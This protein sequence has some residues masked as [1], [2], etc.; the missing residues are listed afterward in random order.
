MNIISNL[1]AAF[2]A[3]VIGAGAV[4]AFAWWLFRQFSER[5]LNAKFEERL[6]A[7][8]HE[9]QKELE[10]LKFAINAQMD[11]ATK[12]HQREFDALPEAWAKLM[13]AYGIIISLVSRGQSMPDLSRM[14][15]AQL[16]DFLEH[17]KLASWERET[18]RESPDKTNAYRNAIEPFKIARGRKAS[19]KFY[20]YFR[21]NGIF[22]REPIKQKFVELDNLLLAAMSEHQMN[23]Q[24][25]TR[26]FGSIDKLAS[27]GETMLKSLEAEIQ[28]RLWDSAAEAK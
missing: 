8:K 16:D 28:K 7:Y 4:G 21:S 18:V 1:L 12:L 6:A 24:D 9:Q 17:S 20:L 14:T 5:W 3:V 11:R 13:H 2:G 19:Q 23:F 26:E 25:R 10:H 27:E 22:I 15:P